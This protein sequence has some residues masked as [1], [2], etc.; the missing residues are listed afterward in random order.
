MAQQH[1]PETT[2][3]V[4]LLKAPMAQAFFR[5]TRFYPF[6][7][8]TNINYQL[9]RILKSRLDGWKKLFVLTNHLESLHLK[10]P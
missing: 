5:T 9:N 8:D 7:K 4:D 10:F 1:H 6:H 3:N 2:E